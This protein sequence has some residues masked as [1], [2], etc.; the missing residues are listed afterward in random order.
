[1]ERHYLLK[2]LG[3]SGIP[4]LVTFGLTLLSFPLLVRALGDYVYGAVLTYGAA[5][6]IFDVF[7]DFDVLYE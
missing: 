4:K 3:L 7:V 2:V 1:M 6:G 5:L